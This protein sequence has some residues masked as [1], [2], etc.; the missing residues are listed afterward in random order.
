[1]TTTNPPLDEHLEPRAPADSERVEQPP[2]IDRSALR[3]RLVTVGLLAMCVLGILLAV[4]DLRPVV[5]AIDDS[6]PALAAVAIVLELLSCVSF[7]VIFRL[8]FSPLP[9]LT[10]HELAWAQ[11]GSG[12]LLPGGGVGSLAVGGWLLHLAGMPTKRIVQR[13]SGLFFLTSAINVLTLAAAGLVLLLGFAAGPHDALRDGLP[14]IAAVGAGAFVLGLPRIARRI[15]GEHPR[16][17]WMDDIAVGI[18]AARSALARPGWRLLGALG[19]LLFDIAVLWTAFAAVGPLPPLAPLVV[20]YLVGY[21]ANALPV[22][23]GIGVLDGGLVGA[24]VLYGLPVTHAA[25]AVLIYHAIAFWVP[26]LGGT[27]A[28][29]RLRRRLDRVT[30]HSA[31]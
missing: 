13:S 19:Y 30:P 5:R 7:V 16:A 31:R 26:T 9:T 12:A 1:M 28:Y 22:P 8:F 4:P 20:A 25:A 17:A 23:G 3:R 27:L 29:L 14:V 6:N 2:A 18:P 15:S 21:L 10:A 11:M 24:L